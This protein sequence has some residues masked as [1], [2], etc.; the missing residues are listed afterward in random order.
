MHLPEGGSEEDYVLQIFPTEDCVGEPAVS[1]RVEGQCVEI[2]GQ[3][4]CILASDESGECVRR[5]W[6]DDKCEQGDVDEVYCTVY[7][8]SEK[9][10]CVDLV[11]TET[12]QIVDGVLMLS[13]R[14]TWTD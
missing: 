8:D 4:N 14:E 11:D 6:Q 3:G 7:Y 1:A 10:V 13:M 5:F 9:D 12:T 2:D